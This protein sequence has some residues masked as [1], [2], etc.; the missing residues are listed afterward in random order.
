MLIYLTLVAVIGA[1][2]AF[3]A[4]HRIVICTTFA[5]RSDT[6]SLWTCQLAGQNVLTYPEDP[7]LAT[8]V[9]PGSD[10]PVYTTDWINGTC[11][12]AAHH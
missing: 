9:H 7:I 3:N 8:V 12:D 10:R 4:R 6:A 11:G 2:L 1:A 5:Q